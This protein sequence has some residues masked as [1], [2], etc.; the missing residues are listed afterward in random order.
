[1]K[2]EKIKIGIIGVGHLGQH[3]VKHYHL[4][5]DAN[6]VGVYDTDSKRG[7]EIAT[8]YNTRFVDNPSNLMELCDAISI[9]TPTESHFNVA[10]MAI[11]DFDCHVFIEKP[12]T[13]TIQQ[14]DEL[15]E[16]AKTKNKII[17]VG[18]IE[19]LNPAL[20]ALDIYELNPKF[21]E[22]QRLAPYTIRGTD[23]PVVLDLMI[24]DIDILLSLVK[25]DVET[26]HA[27]GVSIITDSVDIAHARIRF[28][29]GTVSS[30]TSSRV[31]KDKVRKIK[32]FQENLYSTIDL[33][34]EQTEIYSVI[35][36][37]NLIPSAL[38]T[39][40]FTQDKK[41][42]Y[43]VYEKPT[44]EKDD[45][46]GL[47]IKNFISSTQGKETPIVSGIEA[48]NALNVAIKIHDMILE[49]LK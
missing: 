19:R 10:K 7:K 42:K 29:N 46:L 43:I 21:I 4:L 41:E 2:T 39:E 12:I 44:L 38:Y 34:L 48:R 24:H 5:S 9:V 3:H 26:I 49:D 13:K 16:L 36:D 35:K 32:I 25:S 27:S 37:P 40:P 31:A 8:Q 28:N 20:K 6:L 22:I 14:A 17:Q 33:L 15:I 47:E 18:H 1:M 23:V 30:V 11:A 45:L